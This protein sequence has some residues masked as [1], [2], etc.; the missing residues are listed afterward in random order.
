ME[1]PEPRPLTTADRLANEL[2]EKHPQLAQ[3]ARDGLYDDF[4]SP[5][6][7]PKVALLKDLLAVGDKEL[8]ERVSRGDF[9]NTRE[10]ALA[11]MESEEGLSILK[12]VTR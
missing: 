11:F 3:R 6:A 8:A 9:D 4:R 5:L 7:F 12:D 2:E 10:D 1:L